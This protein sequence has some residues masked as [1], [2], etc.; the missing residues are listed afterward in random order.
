MTRAIF[1]LVVVFALAAT[2]L[3]A[4]QLAFAHAAVTACAPLIGANLP[5]PP[6]QLLCQFNQPLD[7][8]KSTLTVLDS[9]GVRVDKNDTRF[10]EGDAQTLVV[11]LDTSK[12]RPGIYTVRWAVTDTLDFGATS[13]EVQFGVNT[14]VPPTATAEL[15][16][17]AVTPVPAAASGASSELI[18]RFLIAAGVVIL[19]AVGVLFW[20][21]RASAPTDE[22]ES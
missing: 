7:E 6:S 20:R 4:P 8:N 13:G 10:F 14:V 19:A 2:L 12:I 17:A 21:M 5:R 16:G 11:S 15:P 9:Q 1:R 18:S 22:L 3:A